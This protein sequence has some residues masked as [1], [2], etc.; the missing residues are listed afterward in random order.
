MTRWPVVV[1]LA[2]CTIQ[3]ASG[4]QRDERA[5][6]LIGLARVKRDAGD[7]QAARRYFEAARQARPL[8]PQELAEYFWVLADTDGR[9]ALEV[10]REVLRRAPARD[11]VRH[12]VIE[13]AMAAGD[14]QIVRAVAGE[15]HTLSPGVARWSRRL[16]ESFMRTREIGRAA[17]AYRVAAAAADADPRDRVGLAIALEAQGDMTGA[18][19]AW[20]A[21]PMGVTRA[22]ADWVQSRLRVMAAGAPV[23]EAALELEAWLSEHPGDVA[24]RERLVELWAASGSPRRALE[25]MAPLTAGPDRDRWTRREAQIA[26]AAGDLPRAIGALDRLLAGSKSTREDRWTLAELLLETGAHERAALVARE[27][28][29]SNRGCEPRYFTFIDRLPNPAGTDLILEG[30]HANGCTDRPEWIRRGVER[31]VAEGRHRDALGLIARLPA[32]DDDMQRLRGQL[33]FWTGEV[34]AAIGPLSAAVARDP[35]DHAARE[36]LVDAH[37]ATGRP[38]AAWEA[39]G[40]LIHRSGLPAQRLLMLAELALEADRPERAS[41]LLDRLPGDQADARAI[42]AGRAWLAQ[43]RPSLAERTLRGVPADALSPAGVLALLDSIIAVNGYAAAVDPARR[44]TAESTPWQDVLVRRTVIETVAGDPARAS[45]LLAVLEKETPALATLAAA[46]VALAQGRPAEALRRLEAPGQD[47]Y[48]QRTADLRAVALAGTGDAAAAL[49]IVTRLRAERPRFVP[50]VVR[51][52]QLAWQMDPSRPKLE[53]LL[54]TAAAFPGHQHAAFAAAQALASE[55]RASEALEWLP[56]TE[57]LPEGAA[58]LRA[59]LQADVASTPEQKGRILEEAIIR[60][61]R[62]AALHVSLA[63]AR[64]AAGDHEGALTAA[65]RAT[66]L[67]PTDGEAWFVRIDAISV[68]GSRGDLVDAL[69]TLAVVAKSNPALIVGM[70]DH[71]AGLTRGPDDPVILAALASLDALPGDTETVSRSLA[72]ARLFA[73]AERWPEALTA[74]DG[75]LGLHHRSQPALRLRADVLSWAGRHAEAVLAY[76]T[77]LTVAAGDLEARRQQA[78][79]LGWSGRYTEAVRLYD[80]MRAAHPGDRSLAAEAAAKRAFFAGRWRAAAG[81]YLAWLEIEPRN[82]EACFELAEALRAA[83]DDGA[84][85]AALATLEAATGHRLAAI[86]RERA[87]LNRRPSMAFSSDRRA[88]EGYDGAR[89]LELQREGGALGFTLGSAGQTTIVFDGGRVRADG[90]TE[91]RAGSAFTTRIATNVRPGV[92]L[93]GHAASW[94]L[95]SQGPLVELRAGAGWRPRD[96]WTLDLGMERT[97]VFENVATVD[98]GLT[99]TGPFGGLRF[100]GRS[101]SIELRGSRQALSDGNSRFRMSLSARHALSGVLQRV[102]VLAWA[103][104][105]TYRRSAAGYFSPSHFLRVDGGLEYAHPLRQ[106]RFQGDGP[107]EAVFGYLVGTDNRGALYHHPR[108]R[109]ALEL[110]RGLTLDARGGWIRSGSYDETS[111]AIGLRIG[112]ATA[113]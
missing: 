111:F 61:P 85:D 58:V 113:R 88:S 54:T 109:L 93:Y 55:H 40:P 32:D 77:Y 56:S 23:E 65:E 49:V 1:L 90:G 73:A 15:G 41:A 42:M 13:A 21:V 31:T 80:E 3:P 101:S 51:E 57:P 12:A 72:R 19:A 50:Y 71:V 2:L 112:G 107:G 22:Q 110:R 68:T 6:A 5:E 48:A 38:Y 17:D 99:G 16:G 96:L 30:I 33:L 46:E 83:G 9:T 69:R 4:A 84:A 34:A 62:M 63:L 43:G 75:A 78:R 8:H 74:I 91:T 81:A 98:D 26:R 52:A 27:I 28:S 92:Q 11:D 108:A 36:A 20:R 105:L 82:G 79:V 44:F 67:A 87:R 106:A 7:M 66:A 37:R 95:G 18:A 29:Q 103:E 89:L 102:R 104:E 10:G 59:R 64:Q 70:A 86:A 39:A 47:Q 25:T 35:E 76:D 14:E 60:F 45:R 24:T 94:H 53:R 100:N 97:A